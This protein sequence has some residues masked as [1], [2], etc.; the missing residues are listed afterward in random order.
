M[1]LLLSKGYLKKVEYGLR[2]LRSDGDYEWV[3]RLTYVI[4]STGS[5]VDQNPGGVPTTAP[6]TATSFCSYLEKSKAFFDLSPA[7]QDAFEAALPVTRVGAEE[8]QLAAGSYGNRVA[9]NGTAPVSTA[10]RSSRTE[11]RE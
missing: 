1:A 6:N 9:T 11:R 5:L 4:S 3:L 10:Q 8:T 7:E 2:R